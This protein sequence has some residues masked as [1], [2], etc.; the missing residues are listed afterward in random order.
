MGD[1]VQLD[2]SKAQPIAPPGGVTLD[3]SRAQRIPNAGLAPP[4]GPSLKMDSQGPIGENVTSF[5]AQLSKMPG[6][7]YHQIARTFI[8]G[9][10]FNEAERERE[11]EDKKLSEEPFLQGIADTARMV[12]RKLNPIVTTDPGTPNEQIDYGATAA[13]LAPVA[14]DTI[15]RVPLGRVAGAGKAG[16][17]AA[18]KTALEEIPVA[19]PAVKAG[20][21]AGIRNFRASAPVEPIYPGAPLPEHP[22]TFP[23]AHLPEHPGTFPGAHLPETPAAEVLHPELVSE[24]R[25]LPGHIGKEVT[26]PGFQTPEPIPSRSG[27]MLESPR[28]AILRRLGDRASA[29][30][31]EEAAAPPEEQPPASIARPSRPLKVN[32]KKIDPQQDLTSVMERSVAAARKQRGLPVQ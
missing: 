16:V 19:G 18:A 12:G 7:V 24:S 1:P 2:F 20:I 28:D 4:A 29:I 13:N 31:Q 8:P 11:A 10:E 32:G 9:K 15:A 30:Q 6:A 27:L 25:T 21:K 23:G 5:G 26:R 17:V 14:L 3:F 22:G